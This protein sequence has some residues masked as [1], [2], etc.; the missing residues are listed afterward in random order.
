MGARTSLK[1]PS[2]CLRRPDD[3]RFRQG[4][5]EFAVVL[6]YENRDAFDRSATMLRHAGYR[7]DK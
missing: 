3:E 7:L 5:G 6:I 1:K 2:N 4:T